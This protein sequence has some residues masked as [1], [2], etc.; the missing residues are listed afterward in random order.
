MDSSFE[1]N[2]NQTS[3]WAKNDKGLEDCTLIFC[4]HFDFF[5]EMNFWIKFSLYVIQNT[6]TF[7]NIPHVLC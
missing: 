5:I 6:Y 4:G 2:H 7:C 1:S 3:Q